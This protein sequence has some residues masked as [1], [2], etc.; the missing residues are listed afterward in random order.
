MTYL[1]QLTILP[2]LPPSLGLML[3][4]NDQTLYLPI[5][6]IQVQYVAK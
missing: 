2:P 6:K 5:I 1:G 4:K 3:I